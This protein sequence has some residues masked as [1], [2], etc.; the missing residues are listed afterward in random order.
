MDTNL[1]SFVRIS[2]SITLFWTV[3]T[4]ALYNWYIIRANDYYRIF[5]YLGDIS[6]LVTLLFAGTVYTIRRTC[7]KNSAGRPAMLLLRFGHMFVLPLV[8]FLSGVS[9][10]DKDKIRN[11]YIRVNNIRLQSGLKSGLKSGRKVYGPE[12]ILVLLPHC[13]QN[14]NCTGRVTEDIRNCRKCGRCKIGVLSGMTERLNIRTVVAS[15][16]TAAR[17][18]VEAFR[19]RLV[20]AV[21]CERE[22]IA[23]IADIGSIPVLGVINIRPNGFCNNTSVDVAKF[24]ELL[25]SVVGYRVIS[26]KVHDFADL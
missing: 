1:K 26:G 8:I 24:R 11:I 16:G 23:G 2:N 18:E 3:T 21:A 17:S 4:A 13:M 9:R 7:I 10:L 12:Q 5:L 22:L 15:G 14:K 20:L 25:L 6:L 19:P